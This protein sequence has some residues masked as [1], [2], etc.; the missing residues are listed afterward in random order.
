MTAYSSIL[1]DI[2]FIEFLV[3]LA[4]AFPVY[5]Y[6][7]HMFQQ[8][9]YKPK[10]QRQWLR[11]NASR[12][13]LTKAL[14]FVG[15][16]QALCTMVLVL[17]GS[18]GGP[19]FFAVTVLFA[20]AIAGLS[21]AAYQAASY[22]EKYASKKPLVFTPRVKR[23]IAMLAALIAAICIWA[24]FFG[25][26]W[27]YELFLRDITGAAAPTVLRLLAETGI[28]AAAV[29]G[30][31]SWS[32]AFG[33]PA[34]ALD[35]L[36]ALAGYLVLLANACAAPIEKHINAGFINDAKA[37]LEAHR[38]VGMKVIGITGSYGKTSV[39]FFLRDILA[40]RYSVCATPSSFNTPMGL[41]RTI[42]EKMTSADRIFLAE[43]GARN[44]GDIAELCDLV[45]PD[46]GVITAVGPQHLLTFGSLDNVKKT[47]FELADAVAARDGILFLNG[48]DENIADELKRHENR[49]VVIYRTET[50]GQPLPETGGRDLKVY[51][52]SSIATG[53]HGTSFTVTAPDGETQAFE[54]GLV[55]AYNV[56][57]VLAA[58]ALAHVYGVP[59]REAVIPVRRLQSI[60]HRMQ[61]KPGG[62]NVTIID[63]AYNSNPVG[64]KAAVETLGMIGDGVKILLTPGMVELGERQA[65]YNKAFGGYAAA[66]GIDHILL[67]KGTSGLGDKN[68]TAIR[69]GALEKGFDPDKIRIFDSFNEAYAYAVTGIRTDEHRY[70]LFENDLT[71][72]Y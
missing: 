59:L 52:A 69:E 40:V 39:K 42:R 43:M 66:A 47:K 19:G 37:I 63:D 60:E 24:F 44:V 32:L 4:A 58:I 31:V 6:V 38:R 26:T 33:F 28:P 18:Y 13:R 3:V 45:H 35:I 29:A 12:F 2:Y 14:F 34:F 27:L 48:D 15:L 49:R 21:Y 17:S 7:L 9:G 68:C 22:S 16:A 70:I 36:L 51:T 57:N 64:S 54:T 11:E 46:D 62:P 71:D 30:P 10:E 53:R 55:G 20:A 23:L 67:V 25:R 50:G 41:V 72:N 56:I 1:A 65:D 61:L 8:N 5:R